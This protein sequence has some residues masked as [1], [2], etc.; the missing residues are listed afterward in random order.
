M[1]CHSD[2][3]F[4]IARSFDK[5]KDPSVSRGKLASYILHSYG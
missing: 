3:F 4:G 5:L 2:C 1:G